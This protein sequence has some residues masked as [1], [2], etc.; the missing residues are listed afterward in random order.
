MR[1][2]FARGPKLVDP[3]PGYADESGKCPAGGLQFGTDENPSPTYALMA[4][5][6]IGQGPRNPPPDIETRPQIIPQYN[7]TRGIHD[8]QLLN[9]LQQHTAMGLITNLPGE[10]YL[11]VV[12]PTIPGQ[13]R[14]IG[15]QPSSFVPKGGSPQQW[16]NHVAAGVPAT[17]AP[18]GPGQMLG[19][20]Q[21]SNPGSGG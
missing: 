1:N 8:V 14:L 16:A 6:G 12:A 2:P 19:G 4:Y 13:T 17:S 3:L 5:T 11:N 10:G 7:M 18:G 9:G 20:S 21:L 15:T